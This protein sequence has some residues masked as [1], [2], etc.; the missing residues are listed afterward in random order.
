MSPGPTEL[1]LTGYSTGLIK[2]PR[3]KAGT[4]IPKNQLADILTQGHF[5]RDE[6]NHLLCLFNICLFS[7]QSCSKAMAK[8]PQEGDYE[9][10]VVDKSEPVRNL[11][12]RSRAGTPTVPP[13]TASSSPANFGPKD[14]EVSFEAR[15]VRPVAQDTQKDLTKSETMDDSQVRHSDASSMAST[16]GPV[17]WSSDQIMKSQTSTR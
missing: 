17:A 13:S 16:G 2:T 14:H 5:T 4:S 9:E 6:W 7:S 11:V 1:L 8:R 10:R 12:S 3:S 15:T